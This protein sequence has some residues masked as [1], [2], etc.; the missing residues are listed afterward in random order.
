MTG[1]SIDVE[2]LRAEAASSRMSSSTETAAAAVNTN[3]EKSSTSLEKN[4]F[5]GWNLLCQA[6]D[7]LLFI[8]YLAIIL[9]FMASYL[10]G[11]AIALSTAPELKLESWISKWNEESNT[12]K[13]VYPGFLGSLRPWQM[14]KCS[15]LILAKTL[16][17]DSPLQIWALLPLFCRIRVLVCAENIRVRDHSFSLTEMCISSTQHIFI[18]PYSLLSY[19]RWYDQDRLM[20]C[21][22][23]NGAER[24]WCISSLF[25]H[26]RPHFSHPVYPLF[27]LREERSQG[28][29]Q[30]G[31]QIIYCVALGVS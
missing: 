7:R 14:S 11:A 16:Y 30:K 8:A 1:Y 29:S 23:L 3:E 25:A 28:R 21:K 5:S 27:I 2:A 19:A 31:W 24:K 4:G 13:S 6:I 15:R 12:T 17:L 18:T 22:E 26:S 10:G 20:D 9:I